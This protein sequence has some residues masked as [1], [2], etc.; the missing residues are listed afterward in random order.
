MDDESSEQ[1]MVDL[2]RSF[3]G[4][5]QSEANVDFLLGPGT[6]QFRQ[7]AAQVADEYQVP[8]LLWS[9]P[10]ELADVGTS[11][12]TPL[13]LFLEGG[14]R[15][16]QTNSA[17]VDFGRYFQASTAYNCAN[18]FSAPSGYY[19]RRGA[20]FLTC[21]GYCDE[22]RDLDF[23][24]RPDGGLVVSGQWTPS[25][26][27]VSTDWE[28]G[29]LKGES[30]GSVSVS[31]S[32]TLSLGRSSLPV[33]ILS[34]SDEFRQPDFI[35]QGHRIPA[36]LAQADVL[37]DGA[38][39][40]YNQNYLSPSSW[41]I[42]IRQ[43][44]TAL[45]CPATYRQRA[46]ENYCM[47]QLCSAD[48]KEDVAACC[49]TQ[50]DVRSDVL[51]KVQWSSVFD[52]L[53]RAE[54]WAQDVLQQLEVQIPADPAPDADLGNRLA[55]VAEFLPSS[56]YYRDLCISYMQYAQNTL[57][58]QTNISPFAVQVAEVGRMLSQIFLNQPRPT[59]LLIC[60][61]LNFYASSFF[62][63]KMNQIVFRSVISWAPWDKHLLD[64]VGTGGSSL[65][66]RYLEPVPWPSTTEMIRTG[67]RSTDPFTVLA[68]LQEDYQ[69]V[70]NK[71]LARYGN[72]PPPLLFLMSAWQVFDALALSFVAFRIQSF[73]QEPFGRNTK[74]RLLRGRRKPEQRGLEF[75]T[76]LSPSLSFDWGGERL[77]VQRVDVSTQQFAADEASTAI[78][79]A[80]PATTWQAAMARYTYG[81]VRPAD[82]LQGI[83]SLDTSAALVYPCPKG[84]VE[85]GSIC[86]PCAPGFFRAADGNA[87]QRC[88]FGHYQD[89]WAGSQCFLCPEG[90]TCAPN[91]TDAPVANYGWFLEN[92]E[93]ALPA[94]ALA[95]LRVRFCERNFALFNSASACSI[96]P[97]GGLY[98][99]PTSDLSGWD[100][101][102][103]IPFWNLYRCKPAEICLGGNICAEGHQGEHCASCKA[104]YS[105]YLRFTQVCEVCPDLLNQCAICAG[106]VALQLFMAAWLS[107]ATLSSA[108]ESSCLQAPLA[109]TLLQ[110]LQIYSLL[111]RTV[112]KS[113][114]LSWATMIPV[115]DILMT[116]FL[117][118]LMSCLQTA[119]SVEGV[120]LHLLS[121][122]LS[123]GFG[124]FLVGL[125]F[126]VR[127]RHRNVVNDFLR[128]VLALNV[129]TLPYCIYWAVHYT[130]FCS[131]RE[132]VESGPAAC[133]RASGPSYALAT[134]WFA[135]HCA[136]APLLPVVRLG[137]VDAL[138]L[139]RR[140]PSDRYRLWH[141]P[142]AARLLLCDLRSNH[143]CF[144]QHLRAVAGSCPAG[145]DCGAGDPGCV[146][147]PKSVG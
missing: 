56:N 77:E 121:I 41:S 65:K 3:V 97:G 44:C 108:A 37:P 58:W 80:S 109:L 86:E 90:A 81:V 116:P 99:F 31:I 42:C 70:S 94:S 103:Q 132:V 104:G 112:I 21:D 147:H 50:A 40:T 69:T 119:E 125:R 140:R 62:F 66:Y 105:R 39:V 45:T 52:L 11:E 100:A 46:G 87:C 75:K 91:A 25:D 60:G 88:P 78:A 71:D 19:L 143:L 128:H 115:A 16:S 138:R 35:V 129:V 20:E 17:A 130:T 137:R 124:Y 54:V 2:Y 48:S 12:Q 36:E 122:V 5:N 64:T 1:N 114:N 76:F 110:S 49:E 68:S 10:D 27:V 43:N 6:F 84:C 29:C 89:Q 72:F 144:G 82:Q 73:D 107:R 142:E 23:C 79:G 15:S 85:E 53:P 106:V 133:L 102:K 83:L 98:T 51:F 57:K 30:N 135:V 141:H 9:L 134:V 4:A 8:M 61:S 117:L 131:V 24:C 96:L 101:T 93:T 32:L 22:Q 118:P 146:L 18:N 26:A 139:G 55:C 13:E 63:M 7:A 59:V 34:I 33:S 127:I 74:L 111:L 113:F 92:R 14:A 123:A 126:L 95:A 38:T 136:S 28:D 145:G 120:Q 47:G 67:T